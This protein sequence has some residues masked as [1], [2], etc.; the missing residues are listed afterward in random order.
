MSYEKDY[1]QQNYGV[2]NIADANIEY[3]KAEQMQTPEEIAQWVIDNRY[4]KSEFN[5]L[6]D[7]ELFLGLVDKIRDAIANGNHISPTSKG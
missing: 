5:K 1:F 4:P 6:S 3:M 7:Q 2:N